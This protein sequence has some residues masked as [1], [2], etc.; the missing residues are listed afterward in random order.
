VGCSQYST[1]P[2]AVGFHNFSAKYN[3]YFLGDKDLEAA[4]FV[5]DSVFKDDYNQVLPLLLP[6]D[7]V[8]SL[9]VKP[10]L[11]SAIK[12]ASVVAD[13][14]QNSKWID[15]AYYILGKSRLYLGE[16]P[17]GLEALRYVYANGTDEADKNRA[18]I[19]LMRAYV[20]KKDFSNAL[21]V[22]EYMSQQPLSKSLQRDFYLTKAYLHQQNG[23]YLK[24]VAILEETFPLLPRSKEK[25]RAYFA[26][27]QMYDRLGEYGMAIERYKKVAKTHPDYNLGFYSSMSALQN[28]VVLNPNTDLSSVGFNK[29]LKDRKNL[30]LK[31]RIYYTMGLLEEH[32]KNIPQAI[33]YLQK[34]ASLSSSQI[35]SSKAYT[36]LQLAR[37]HYDRLEKFDLAKAYYDSALVVLPQE[38]PEFLIVSERKRALD[39][40]AKQYEIVSREDSLQKLAKLPIAALNSRIDQIIDDIEKKRLESEKMAKEK[41]EAAAKANNVASAGAGN[42]PQFGNERRWELY[43]P[44]LIN[45]GKIEFK[46]TWGNRDLEDNW[47]RSSKQASSITSVQADSGQA[48]APELAK[49]DKLEKGSA[50]WNDFHSTLKANI[51]LSDSA[52]QA[53]L[54]NKENAL[55]N[56]GKIYRFDLKEDDRAVGTFNRLLNEYPQTIYRDELYYLMFLTINEEPEK[57]NWRKK[58]LDEFPQSTY[59][60]LLNKALESN[61]V[62]R[63]N[64]IKAYESAYKQYAMGNYPQTLEEI[65]KDMPAYQGTILEDKF[66]LLRVFLI[67]HVRG[68]EAYLQAINEFIRLYPT[69]IY[70]PRVK[71]M[72]ELSTRSMGRK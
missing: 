47:R 68:K 25:A 3:A 65:E 70:L 49:N 50:A 30:D 66:A 60:R 17:E 31:D 67:G 69:S 9:P 35:G 62:D 32:K 15:N 71:E 22:A 55:Y 6:M 52:M 12:K 53:S 5:M 21:G 11:T 2:A 54:S 13:K 42:A 48:A 14:H 64:P 23:E 45:I 20:Y 34:S 24:S 19:L 1:K 33:E 36:Y 37:I 56:L 44:S 72:Q 29:M 4:E 61:E 8:L 10:L 51:P 38:A 40:F 59:A 46:R 39:T 41:A 26:A 7:S 57:G 16:W 27:G 28:Q 63:T 58:L 18:L 43:D